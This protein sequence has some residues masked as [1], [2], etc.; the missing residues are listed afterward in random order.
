MKVKSG[1]I[2]SIRV[3]SADHGPAYQAYHPQG[4]FQAR[5]QEIHVR[6]RVSPIALERLRFNDCVIIQLGYFDPLTIFPF[7]FLA[8]FLF[9]LIRASR[10]V[11]YRAKA[12]EGLQGP[13]T[14]RSFR[15]PFPEIRRRGLF[16]KNRTWLRRVVRR[17]WVIHVTR[18]PGLTGICEQQVLKKFWV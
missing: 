12:V 15:A 5:V 4:I 18:P 2:H 13:R 17:W 8:Q 9:L 14:I 10:E 11:L 6:W 16:Q 1:E 3:G 7:C